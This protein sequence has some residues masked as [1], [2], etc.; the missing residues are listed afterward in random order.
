MEPRLP[1]QLC[2]CEFGVQELATVEGIVG[3]AQPRLRAEIARR[4]CDALG[5]QDTLGRAKLMSA[6][7]LREE[8]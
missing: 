2:G 8:K 3:S 6:R 1:A 4:V 7:R 5:W